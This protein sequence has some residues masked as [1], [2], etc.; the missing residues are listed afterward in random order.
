MFPPP[1]LCVDNGVM[2]AHAAIEYIQQHRDQFF[3]KTVNDSPTV[4]TSLEEPII[5]HTFSDPSNNDQAVEPLARWLL[6]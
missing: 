3:E 5:T 4:K 1:H 6:G 2:I